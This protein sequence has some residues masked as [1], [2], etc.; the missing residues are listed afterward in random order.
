MNSVTVR[1]LR[2]DDF[3]AFSQCFALAMGLEIPP[4]AFERLDGILELEGSFVAESEG[5]V[6]GTVGAYLFELSTPGRGS[7][8]AVGT[9]LVAVRPTHR[10]RGIL[11]KMMDAHTSWARA[12]G[13]AVMGLWASETAIYPRFGF[14]VASHRGEWRI[15]PKR[16]G[17]RLKDSDAGDKV[18]ILPI[19]KAR[20]RIIAI[21]EEHWKD[22]GGALSRSPTWW[23]I[24]RFYDEPWTRAGASSFK[25]A[26]SS[27]G[28]R[29][30]GYL[31]YR[32]RSRWDDGIANDQIILNELMG[33]PGGQRAL[34][35]FL[36][37]LDLVECIEAFNLPVDDPLP[38]YLGDARR[39][40]VQPQDA[41]WLAI[42]DLR[43]VLS[44][45]TYATADSL[46]LTVSGPNDESE[47]LRLTAQ[48]GAQGACEPTSD[49]PDVV[50]LSSD[51]VSILW[52]SISVFALADAHRISGSPEALDRLARLMWTPRL[53]WCP[54]RF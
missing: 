12:R 13:V 41:L 10:R 28:G 20:S 31:Q 29:D 38:L 40:S 53:P 4:E 26:I 24:R 9:T 27:R 37:S 8:P 19:D 16:A 36:L 47:T 45:R 43:Q 34:W 11:R 23:E 2:Q 22:R 50:L 33:D 42:I 44:N 3:P 14:G 1:P 39:A 18:Q 7:I 48:A 17:F 49:A 51:L 6:V 5:E 15:S 52:G 54:E 21:Y 46:T 30:T 25:Y 35:R 32:R